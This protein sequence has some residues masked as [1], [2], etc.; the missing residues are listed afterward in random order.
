MNDQNSNFKYR[1]LIAL[2]K[3]LRISSILNQ[4]KPTSNHTQNP[5]PLKTTRKQQ[6]NTEI[7]ASYRLFRARSREN[8]REKFNFVEHVE[9]VNYSLRPKDEIKMP[10][11]LY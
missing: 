1:K 9:H 11:F 5:N 8:R 3:L 2:R 7:E 4:T 6:D 10:E